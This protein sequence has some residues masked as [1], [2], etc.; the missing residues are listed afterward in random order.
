MPLFYVLLFPKGE[1]G[2]YAQIPLYDGGNRQFVTQRQYYTF[3][4]QIRLDT[5]ACLLHGGRLLQ[6]FIVDAYRSLEELRLMWLRNNQTNL[7]AK[8]YRGLTNMLNSHDGRQ[9]GFLGGIGC[10]VV[11]PYSFTGGPMYMHQL[12]QDSMAIVHKKGKPDL[13]ITFTCNLNG[14]K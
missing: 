14:K 9:Q 5:N 6:Q 3:H 4:L 13:F 8:V 12:Y 7:R 1:D 11:L 10:R 2:W